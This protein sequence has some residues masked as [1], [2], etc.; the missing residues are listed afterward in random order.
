MEKVKYT[1]SQIKKASWPLPDNEQIRSKI[2]TKTIDFKGNR[3]Y[4]QRE[5]KPP[6]TPDF[7]M[8]VTT[9]LNCASK[10][11]GFDKWLG[12]SSNYEIC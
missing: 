9:W 10:G 7:I 4:T 11:I 8:S 12:N 2:P 5:I 1:D 6:E 3:Y